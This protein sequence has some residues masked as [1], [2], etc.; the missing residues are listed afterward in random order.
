MP[1]QFW[2]EPFR[3]ELRAIGRAHLDSIVLR[4]IDLS[5]VIQA[6]MLEAFTS[7]PALHRETERLSWLRRIF[8]NNLLDELRRLRSQKRDIR[9][10]VSLDRSVELSSFRVKQLLV[11]EQ[12]SPSAAVLQ[13]ET[14]QQ[15]LQAIKHLPETQRRAIEMHHLEGMPLEKIALELQ[16]PKDAVAALIYRGMTK[17]RAALKR[18]PDD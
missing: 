2:A 7:D 8:I 4:R 5:G 6:T 18:S 9:K 10:E 17:L 14:R 11:G 15:V 3:N 13:A 16:R 12:S 1:G